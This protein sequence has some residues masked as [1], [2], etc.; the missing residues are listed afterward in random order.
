MGVFT[1]NLSTKDICFVFQ[2]RSYRF[3]STRR[4]KI[5]TWAIGRRASTSA[6]HLQCAVVLKIACEICTVLIDACLKE[7]S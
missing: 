7:I 1:T 4:S 3:S 6:D 2:E 5:V